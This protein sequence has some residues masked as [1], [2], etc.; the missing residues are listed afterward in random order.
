MWRPG[1]GHGEYCPIAI[2]LAALECAADEA[3]RRS[4]IS[5]EKAVGDDNPIFVMVAESIGHAFTLYAAHFRTLLEEMKL[6]DTD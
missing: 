2:C 1:R 6:A 5:Y 3:E 4:K